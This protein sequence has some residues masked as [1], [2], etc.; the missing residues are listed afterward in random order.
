M[1][2]LVS[3]SSTVVTTTKWLATTKV[4]RI[5]SGRMRNWWHIHGIISHVFI[6]IFGHLYAWIC[7][8]WICFHIRSD[9]ITRIQGLRWVSSSAGRQ[10][11]VLNTVG[12]RGT[13]EKENNASTD[14]GSLIGNMYSEFFCH[15]DFMWNQFWS[16]WS[17]KNCNLDYLIC[18]EF[19]I[20]VN[21]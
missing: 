6:L 2:F 1:I 14:L 9:H 11:G 20:F 19:W 16:F 8:C 15:S 7:T 4:R 18:S 17:P 21:F 13:S 3:T 5:R 10:F 12:F